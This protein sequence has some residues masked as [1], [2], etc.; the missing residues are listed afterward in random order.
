MKVYNLTNKSD[1]E[2]A[3][4]LDVSESKVQRPG[5]VD[6]YLNE[7]WRGNSSNSVKT[8]KMYMTDTIT[9]AIQHDVDVLVYPEG[10]FANYVFLLAKTCKNTKLEIK[11]A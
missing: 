4:A 7:M 6:L 3:L 10:C 2:V 8:S 9:R 5:E 1:L 11:T